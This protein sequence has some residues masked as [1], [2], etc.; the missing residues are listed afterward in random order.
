MCRTHN[1]ENKEGGG[2]EKRKTFTD[3]T[4]LD[5]RLWEE[6]LAHFEHLQQISILLHT[7]SFNKFADTI[8]L[9]YAFK[10]VSSGKNTD[11]HKQYTHENEYNQKIALRNVC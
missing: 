5:I 2:K 9:E 7:I 1:Y 10:F 4:L 3:I 6:H 8:F 11:I